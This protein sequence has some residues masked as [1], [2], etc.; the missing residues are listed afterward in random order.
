ME[1][2]VSVSLHD[3]V[4]TETNA[5]VLASSHQSSPVSRRSFLQRG[6]VLGATVLGMSTLAAAC[7]GGAPTVSQPVT[8]TV[9]DDPINSDI[10]LSPHWINVF[11][12]QNPQINVKR[13]DFDKNRLSAMLA[14]GTPPDIVKTPGGPD[15]SNLAARGAAKDLTPYFAQSKLLKEDDLQPVCD[16][17]RWD[18]KHQGNGARYG[19]P[20]DWSQ[21]TMY[22]ADADLF[23]QAGIP[24]PS[25]EKPLTFD[26]LLELGKRLAVR[27][28]GKM[29]IYGMGTN[30][31]YEAQLLALLAQSGQSLY[32]DGDLSQPDFT[33]PEVKK[34]FQ[35]YLTWG[36]QHIGD[37]PLDPSSD[38]WGPLFTA[39]RYALV[40]AGMWF[41]GWLE[42]SDKTARQRAVLIPAP[43]WGSTRVSTCY[44]GTGWWIPKGSKHPDEAWKFFEWYMG[45]EPAVY[46][47]QVGYGIS[48]LKHLFET[49]P[50]TPDYNKQAFEV[51]KAELPYFQTLQFTPY[52]STFGLSQIIDSNMIPVFR[53]ENSLDSALSQ[54]QAS[55]NA[56]VQQTKDLIG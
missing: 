21:D 6:A 37:S 45:G 39:K 52:A 14:A 13:I 5:T 22:W 53:G 32:K 24:L 30:W 40:P 3:T 49:F 44:G 11:Q 56:L 9:M 17:Y 18:G 19:M 23:K 16:L 42:G 10:G 1:K 33:Q 29:K 43:Q 31:D 4:S 54:I 51:Q 36:Q 55:V 25:V 26:Q 41:G 47:A 46:R 34:I 7:G 48:P 35:W 20:H 27:E 15:I 8:I 12:R 38:W 28:G 2:Q 50:Q